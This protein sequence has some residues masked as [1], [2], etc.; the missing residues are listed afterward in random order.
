MDYWFGIESYVKCGLR[1]GYWGIY[2]YIPQAGTFST[3]GFAPLMLYGLF[4]KLF[5]WP[6]NG[7]VMS[8]TLKMVLALAAF[9]LVLKPDVRQSLL[10][11]GLSMCFTPI[12]LYST[13]SLTEPVN[14][15]ILLIDAAFLVRYLQKGKWTWLV[16]LCLATA[17][18][19]LYRISYVVLLLP[20]LFAFFRFHGF[21]KTIVAGVIGFAAAFFIYWLT[22]RYT[23]PYSSGFLYHFTHF[24][25]WQDKLLLL[26]KNTWHNFRDMFLK[27]SGNVLEDAT[28]LLYLLTM[29]F[30]CVGTFARVQKEN[31]RY[32]LARRGK[33]DPAY[34]CAALVLAGT[35][36]IMLMLYSVGG[37]RDLRVLAPVMWATSVLLMMRGRPLLAKGMLC[38]SVVTLALFIFSGT[39][40]EMGESK[41]YE[42][43][44]VDPQIAELCAPI[45]Y[46][47]DAENPFENTLRVGQFSD[48][49]M[50]SIPAGI[51]VQN[52]TL[53]PETVRHSEYV[54]SF[55]SEA[56]FEGYEKI[57]QNEK[58]A[59]WRRVRESTAG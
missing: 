12:M 38:L 58:G 6:M 28:R 34:L 24:G 36:A 4:G 43:T 49:I 17:Y 32:R 1:T 33:V 31:G 3:H 10:L 30:C 22:S 44:E 45:V 40:F 25:T 35:L 39:H 29:L 26:L 20:I 23:S 11:T 46:Q 9:V 21:K 47:P 5:G 15:A 13:L 37:R 54:L 16:G 56:N 14:Y 7:I 51:G 2:E 42:L 57:V 48:D 8:N 18:A 55:D 52:A 59:L 41:R 53:F 50:R 27:S 19:C